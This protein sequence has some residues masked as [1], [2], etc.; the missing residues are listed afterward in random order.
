MSNEWSESAAV[1]D[2][3][4]AH[5]KHFAERMVDLVRREIAGKR[6]SDEIKLLDVACGTGIVPITFLKAFPDKLNVL[7]VDL[8]DKMVNIAEQKLLALN[9]PNV[10]TKVMD[11]QV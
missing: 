6:F 4:T 9:V 7:A 8:A 10:S 1:Y 2:F 11:G 3:F 5:T